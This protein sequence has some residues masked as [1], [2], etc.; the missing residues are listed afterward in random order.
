MNQWNAKTKKESENPKIA[1]SRLSDSCY[2]D[3]LC[4]AQEC[5]GLIP[6][7]PLT[8]AELESYEELFPFLVPPQTD[9]GQES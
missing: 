9:K 3:S 5:T 8:D 1:V 2:T 4:S 7:P 6:S